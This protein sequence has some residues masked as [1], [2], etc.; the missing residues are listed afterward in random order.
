[1]N[2]GN[3]RKITDQRFAQR[4][5]ERIDRSVALSS[6][7]NAIAVDVKLDEGFGNNRSAC[8]FLNEHFKGFKDEQFLQLTI[9]LTK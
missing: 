7:V 5:I 8:C 4:V 9:R 6:S 3:T 2:I 1:M